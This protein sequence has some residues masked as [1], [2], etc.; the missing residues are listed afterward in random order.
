MTDKTDTTDAV[1]QYEPQT[2][3]SLQY[4]NLKIPYSFPED[5][6]EGEIKFARG[7][8]V[9]YT[10]AENNLM[11]RLKDTNAGRHFM[12]LDTSSPVKVNIPNDPSVGPQGTK[13][14]YTSDAFGKARQQG[15]DPAS[16]AGFLGMKLTNA[17][18]PQFQA[19]TG[20]QQNPPQSEVTLQDPKD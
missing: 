16:T 14:A 1:K 19:V 2:W 11:K 5:K 18:P 20:N 3:V 8:Y 10:E 4:P 15:V 12:W 13:G 9:A 7:Q 17:P 6:L